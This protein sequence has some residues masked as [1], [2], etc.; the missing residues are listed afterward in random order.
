[1]MQYAALDSEKC[2]VETICHQVRS[3]NNYSDD[4]RD[5]LL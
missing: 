1:M 3:A 4:Y 5:M 2:R